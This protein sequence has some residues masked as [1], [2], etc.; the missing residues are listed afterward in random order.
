MF[1]YE[2]TRGK[3]KDFFNFKL[4]DLFFSREKSS[5]MSCSKDYSADSNLPNSTIDITLHNPTTHRNGKVLK[6][7]LWFDPEK[8]VEQLN[9]DDYFKMSD[10][11]YDERE[12]NNSD[13]LILMP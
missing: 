3:W 12:I 10:L 9:H 5:S 4:S 11:F 8:K 7:K 13:F 6:F 2:I 1:K